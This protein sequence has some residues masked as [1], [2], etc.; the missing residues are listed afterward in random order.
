V[1]DRQLRNVEVGDD[2]RQRRAV[3]TPVVVSGGGWWRVVVVGGERWSVVVVGGE[4]W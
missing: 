1:F 3:P 2:V 4:W